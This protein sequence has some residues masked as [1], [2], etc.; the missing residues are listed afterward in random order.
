M[1]LVGSGFHIDNDGSAQSPSEFRRQHV[2]E[3]L[4]FGDGVWIRQHRRLIVIRGVVVDAVEQKVI[5]L[6]AV[7]IDANQC[8][9][10]RRISGLRHIGAGRRA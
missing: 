6:Y 7:A 2:G 10:V 9:L 5:V 1:V 8:A 3:H 4:E